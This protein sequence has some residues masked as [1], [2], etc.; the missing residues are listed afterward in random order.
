MGIGYVV[1]H[2]FPAGVHVTQC[3]GQI[4]LSVWW[5]MVINGWVCT[6]EVVTGGV[7]VK[8]VSACQDS[9]ATMEACATASAFLM[10]VRQFYWKGAGCNVAH[11]FFLAWLAYQYC[12][13]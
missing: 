5:G 3:P 4:W 1:G 9:I 8:G 13:W 7:N 11:L 2:F 12:A 10:W 6:T